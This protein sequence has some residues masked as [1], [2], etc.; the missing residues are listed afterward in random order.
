[1]KNPSRCLCSWFE[2]DDD[3]ENPKS[4]K[5]TTL[6]SAHDI[7][8]Y[9]EIEAISENNEN[10]HTV[11]DKGVAHGVTNNVKEEGDSLDLFMMGVETSAALDTKKAIDRQWENRSHNRGTD[12]IGFDS[13][14][15]L[16]ENDDTTTRKRIWLD[17]CHADEATSPW[18]MDDDKRT[19][20][21]REEKSNGLRSIDI[22]YSSTN[23]EKKR[24][25]QIR[26]L[27]KLDYSF[28]P[29][30]SFRRS[31]LRQNYTSPLKKYY[32]G[33]IQVTF[34]GN[35]LSKGNQEVYR[36]NNVTP[37]PIDTFEDLSTRQTDDP[38]Q[39]QNVNFPPA[40]FTAL[41]KAGCKRPTPIQRY[42]MPLLLSGF[43]LLCT[44]STG[45]GK[46]LAY[47]LPL[48]VHVCDQRPIVPGQDGP[49]GLI[50]RYVSNTSI[51][52]ERN[53][54]FKFTEMF[55]TSFLGESLPI[56]SL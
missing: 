48:V 34:I 26:P 47:A 55:L 32:D 44:A 13:E 6:L 43:D 42:A 1:M 37:L 5:A 36:E 56:H 35:F 27:D 53:L 54:E 8:S 22:S 45:S 3:D 12:K 51:A 33:D 30:E 15:E 19:E 38:Q 16:W 7:I 11:N 20:I 23:R 25:D 52:L 24:S 4:S 17:S 40:L 29:Y 10:S 2:D 31:F 49:I 50:I 41:S 28:I 14:D 21:G 18:E 39:K 9:S 46:T